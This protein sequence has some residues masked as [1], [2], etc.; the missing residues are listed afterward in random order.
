MSASDVKE[1]TKAELI[2]GL[3]ESRA[4]LAKLRM[5]H[6]VSPLENPKQLKESKKNVA[7][8]LTEIR[9]REIKA[10]TEK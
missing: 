9:A 3:E 6:A 4:V 5:T 1:M 8:Y 2:D 7:R 10:A